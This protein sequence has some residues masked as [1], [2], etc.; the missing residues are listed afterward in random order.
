VTPIRD[1]RDFLFRAAVVA[2]FAAVAAVLLRVAAM[3]AE[4]ASR[5]EKVFFMGMFVA[6]LFGRFT[7]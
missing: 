1:G 3:L 6:F 2:F 7:R 5:E 4:G